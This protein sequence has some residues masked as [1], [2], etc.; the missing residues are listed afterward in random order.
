MLTPHSATYT[1]TPN[2]LHFPLQF[3]NEFYW[4]GVKRTIHLP[5]KQLFVSFFFFPFLRKLYLHEKQQ[6]IFHF[7]SPF[8]SF[9]SLHVW[10]FHLNALHKYV[11]LSKS[12]KSKRHDFEVIFRIFSLVNAGKANCWI[13]RPYINW[14]GW[15]C[16][17]TVSLYWMRMRKE[18]VQIVAMAMCGQRGTVS[19]AVL[20]VPLKWFS[21]HIP[22]G[23][24]RGC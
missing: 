20:P 21:L 12:D 15:C 11:N 18:R 5:L 8:L 16:Q 10:H 6:Q 3:S 24:T 22:V 4:H 23:R 17:F 1:Q 19:K 9:Y 2:L 14:V 7:T 13:K